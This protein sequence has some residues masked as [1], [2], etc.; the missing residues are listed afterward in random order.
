MSDLEYCE[1]IVTADS[2]EWPADFTHRLVDD[3]LA[4]CGQHIAPFQSIY[5]WEGAI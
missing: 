5:R 1:G 4:A 2:A 3:R